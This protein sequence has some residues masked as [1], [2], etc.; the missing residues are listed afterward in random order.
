MRV[1]VVEPHPDDMAFFFSGTIAKLLTKGHQVFT[2]VVTDGEQGT[3]SPMY[4][5]TEKLAQVLRREEQNAC[6]VLGVDSPKFL[7]LKNHFLQPDHSLREL[8]LRHIRTI[9]PEI[10]FTI[11]PWNRDENPDHRA[12]GMATLEACS[13]AHL[14]LFHPEHLEQGLKPAIVSKVALGKTETPDTFIDITD[15]IDKKIEAVLCYQSQIELMWAEGAARLEQL[16]LPGGIF[17]TPP[18]TAIPESLK[19]IAGALGRQANVEFAE[20]FYIR[21]LG[22]LDQIEDIEKGS[23]FNGLSN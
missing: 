21:R 11:D 8:I 19:K 17:T 10:V 7:G 13:F 2:L 5:S 15:Y 6:R 20:A 14:H 4:D 3:M 1:L 22:I 9:Q 12:V 23:L 16:G 18:E